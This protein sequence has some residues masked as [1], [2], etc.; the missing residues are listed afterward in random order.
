MLATLMSSTKK[1]A[2]INAKPA[3]RGSCTSPA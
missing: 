3:T 2:A 1:C